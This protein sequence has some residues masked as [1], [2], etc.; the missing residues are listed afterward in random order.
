[1][2]R[3]RVGVDLA[4]EVTAK[5]NYSWDEGTWPDYQEVSNDAFIIAVDF[6]IKRNILRLLRK[7]A[8]KVMVV[9]AQISF[10]ELMALNPDGVFL[11]RALRLCYQAYSTALTYQYANLWHLS[12]APTPC[13]IRWL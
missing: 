6:G 3:T 12:W 10:D 13:I 5:N 11:S 4:K 1:M 7:H 8:G 9:N 2:Y